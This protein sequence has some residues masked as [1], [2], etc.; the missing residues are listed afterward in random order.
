MPS[1]GRGT[2]S[3]HAIEDFRLRRWSEQPP[4]SMLNTGPKAHHFLSI[5]PRASRIK[6]VRLP[7][8][9]NR[10]LPSLSV[11]RHFLALGGGLCQ[12]E[13]ECG[14]I[15]TGRDGSC[16]KRGPQGRMNLLSL[17]NATTGALGIEPRSLMHAAMSR[18]HVCGSIHSWF[19]FGDD[20]DVHRCVEVNRI[21]R[22]A[23]ERQAWV[24]R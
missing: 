21:W 8:P 2:K 1:C 9:R 11:R 17:F 20:V 3:P 22:F 15:G 7:P 12:I 4:R 18:A 10:E 16:Q 6:I 23:V 24:D 14:G 19:A 5:R 13:Q